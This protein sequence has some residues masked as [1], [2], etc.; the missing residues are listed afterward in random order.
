MTAAD[1]KSKLTK[2]LDFLKVELAKIR[3]NRANP[4]LIEDMLIDAYD[5]K[6]TVKELASIA[7]LDAQNLVVSP[8][9]KNLLKELAKA[10]AESG[11]GLNPTVEND[12]LRIPLPAL[13]EERRKEFVRMAASK[14]EDCKTAMRN[15][16][17]DAMKDIE[18]AFTG[19]DIGEDEKFTQKEEVE[20]IV[21]DF[22]TQADTIGEEKKTDLLLV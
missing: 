21:K 8:W 22:V 6:M 4:S 13:T 14:T 17:H 2:S 20:K 3:T 15:I 18:K 9:D 19:K 5:T 12:H 16:R 11:S 7:V 10:I 1:L